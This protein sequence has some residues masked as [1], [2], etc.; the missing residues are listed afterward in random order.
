MHGRGDGF[1]A[2]L[3]ATALVLLWV[4]AIGVASASGGTPS[5]EAINTTASKA[6]P[7]ASPTP[8]AQGSGY[9]GDD[10]CATCHELEAKGLHQTLHGNSHNGQT[11]AAFFL[12]AEKPA[13]P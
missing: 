7:P 13:G 12:A 8:A 5:P 2:H 4:M 10:T 6:P 3:V 1:P 9:V 11:A